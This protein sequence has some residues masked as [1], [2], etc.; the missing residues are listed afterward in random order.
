MIF[1]P[2]II[3][4]ISYAL[5]WKQKIESVL[6]DFD[7]YFENFLEKIIFVTLIKAYKHLWPK[8]V[9]LVIVN[10][11]W[12]PKDRQAAMTIRG[13]CDHVLEFL[14]Q[15]FKVKPIE[16]FKLAQDPLLKIATP[17]N[18]SDLKPNTPVVDSVVTQHDFL[19]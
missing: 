7:K 1:I 12:T 6:I 3:T 5:C 13:E 4:A 17:L 10:L 14:A 11:Q 18:D 8:N 2:E 9:D 15:Y 19:G 16:D